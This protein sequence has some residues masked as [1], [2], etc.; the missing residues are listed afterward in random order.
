[1]RAVS[2]SFALELCR[3]ALEAANKGASPDDVVAKA[4]QMLE[5]TYPPEVIIEVVSNLGTS[6]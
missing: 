1:M 4:R 5:L 2:A 6:K 3:A